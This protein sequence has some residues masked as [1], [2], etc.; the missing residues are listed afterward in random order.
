MAKYGQLQP[1]DFFRADASGLGR[2]YALA[3]AWIA[4][5]E[6]EDVPARE[7]RKSVAKL[8]KIGIEMTIESVL[9][10]TL[11]ERIRKNRY[12]SK[13]KDIADKKDVPRDVPVDVPVD[14]PKDVASRSRS[15]SRNAT[16]TEQRA[17]SPRYGFSKTACL[18]AWND[19]IAEATGKPSCATGMATATRAQT[20][21][22]VVYGN[23]ETFADVV[24]RRIAA[25]QSMN[26]HWVMNDYASDI[27]RAGQKAKTQAQTQEEW[28]ASIGIPHYS[29]VRQ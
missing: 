15:R 21:H 12:R 19:A 4:Q 29:Q 9:G 28:F 24:R 7:F 8:R 1:E 18:Q 6:M 25:S 11:A 3:I 16:P 5:S 20:F 27:E 17:A 10:A 22:R 14:V 13:S 2:D 26:L 23:S